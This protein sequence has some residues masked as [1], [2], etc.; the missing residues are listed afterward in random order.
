MGMVRDMMQR[1]TLVRIDDTQRRSKV[2]DARRLIY[3]RQQLVNGA[4]VNNL[5]KKESLVPTAVCLHNC[6]SGNKLSM[7]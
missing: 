2:A 5:L 7:K 6:Q 1:K 4:A 3:D